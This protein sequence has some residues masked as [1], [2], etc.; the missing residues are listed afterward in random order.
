[1]NLDRFSTGLPDP[2][3]VPAIAYCRVCRGEIYPGD[4][5]C[6]INGRYIVHKDEVEE[7]T[8]EEALEVV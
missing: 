4:R 8:A 1:M 5:V 6:V 3:E 2:Q 7:M